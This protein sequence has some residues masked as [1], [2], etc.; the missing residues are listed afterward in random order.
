MASRDEGH[1]DHAISTIPEQVAVWI[2]S[3]GVRT[4]LAMAM[5]EMYS[6]KAG[7]AYAATT[8]KHK[9]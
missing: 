1:I 9:E 3:I 2:E 7:P 6:S 5:D 8:V 4:H